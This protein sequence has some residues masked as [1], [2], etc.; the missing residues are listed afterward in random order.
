MVFP[1]LGKNSAKTNEAQQTFV[2]QP[3]NVCLVLQAKSIDIEQA[4]IGYF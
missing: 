1:V 3:R 4:A 2:E